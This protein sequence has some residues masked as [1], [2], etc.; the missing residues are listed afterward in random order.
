M[1][2]TDIERKTR[3]GEKQDR[4][5][6]ER[7]AKRKPASRKRQCRH[8]DRRIGDDGDRAHGG[9]MMTADCQRE[10]HRPDGLPF[11]RPVA[12]TGRQRR[13]SDRRAE[14]NGNDN[15]SGIPLNPPGDLESCHSGVVHRRDAAADDRSTDPAP[16]RHAV[17]GRDQKTSAGKQ[18]GRK[19]R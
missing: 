9:E 16:G 5:R 18:D 10:Q 11:H 3:A 14:R 6:G 1:A 8:Q 13:R 2:F 19:Q 15:E 4:Q 12:Q 7:D 17:C